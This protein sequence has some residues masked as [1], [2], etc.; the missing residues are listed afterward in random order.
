MP[1]ISEAPTPWP[2]TVGSEAIQYRSYVP[3]V[4]GVGP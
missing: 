1:A 3:S 4:I 2:R